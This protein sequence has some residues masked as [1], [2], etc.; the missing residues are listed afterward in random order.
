[1]K[2]SQKGIDLIKEF[3]GFRSKAYLCPG[4]IWTIGYGHTK[5]VRP[6]DIVTQR[7]AEDLLRKDLIE[8][9]SAVNNLIKVNITQNQFDALVSLVY[10]IG[11]GNFVDSTVRKLINQQCLDISR[12]E[13]AWCM[14]KRAG[15]RT[16]SGLMRRREAEFKLFKQ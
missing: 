14:W 6:N 4:G 9:E 15:G 7:Q 12:I 5:G 1:M 2:T 11:V 16:L 10:N 13:H 3:E 8:C